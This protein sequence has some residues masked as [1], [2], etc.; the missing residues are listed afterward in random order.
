ML[1]QRYLRLAAFSRRDAL[2]F[3]LPLAVLVLVTTAILGA[4][5]L[6]QRAA[7]GV[8]DVAATDIVAPRAVEFAS[9]I[10]TEQARQASRAAVL[11]Q[12]DYTS[13]KGAAVA[14]QQAGELN[15]RVAAVDSAFEADLKPDDRRPLL[16]SAISDLGKADRATL[17]E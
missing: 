3:A 8:G 9:A 10:Q 15:V 2:R 17:V 12:Y 5:A 14:N 7:V 11:P 6:P 16:E 13:A 4:D 1:A